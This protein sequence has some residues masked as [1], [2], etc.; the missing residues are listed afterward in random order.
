MPLAV[1]FTGYRENPSPHMPPGTPALCL[2]A[3]DGNTPY[4]I[5]QHVGHV[6]TV[7]G[8]PEAEKLNALETG[9]TRAGK[10][11]DL[12]FRALSW[13]T[14]YPNSQVFCFD[15]KFSMRNLVWALGGSYY[16]FGGNEAQLYL[17]PLCD[18]DTEED[19]AWAANWLETLCT[20]RGLQVSPS[21]ANDLGAALKKLA[22]RPR[23][24]RS[25][26][27]LLVQLRNEELTA[28]LQH[29]TGAS[30]ASGGLLDGQTDP[31][32]TE[33]ICDFEMEHLMTM[34]KRVMR[35][36]LLYL[37]RVVAKR[38][39]TRRP[40]LITVDE[41]WTALDDE[42]FAEILNSWLRELNKLNAGVILCT[43]NTGDFIGKPL[44]QV[45]LN[46]CPTRN[47]LPTPSAKR[48]SHADYV[49]LGLNEQ[50]I[51]RIANGTQKRDY[52][53]H[54]PNGFQRYQIYP[55]AV[56][57]AFLGRNSSA[58]RDRI[59]SLRT[60]YPEDWQVYWLRECGLPEWANH[61]EGL[62]S[63]ERSRTECLT[64]STTT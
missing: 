24:R 31:L 29:Y 14:R 56:M 59:S 28:A 27:E 16:P 17:A 40:T 60:E 42:Y 30:P 45:I 32:G 13:L 6:T 46:Q 53:C 11:F 37:F 57:K 36:I 15:K 38:L 25:L 3:T 12:G 62:F 61:L 22:G 49:K 5:N 58:D 54:S 63:E 64:Y 44:E 39:D 33:P 21:G 4:Y 18:I 34:D 9:E 2:A 55:G 8:K 48:A 1:P 10:S 19:L 47:Y 20:M 7:N 35:A 41:A 51:D 26:T 43:Q 52:F 50:Q 23:N